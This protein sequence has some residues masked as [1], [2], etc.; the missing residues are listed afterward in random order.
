MALITNA[1]VEIIVFYLH[2][3]ARHYRVARELVA[4]SRRE[5][6]STRVYM[7]E[8]WLSTHTRVCDAAP[9]TGRNCAGTVTRK[10]VRMDP[11]CV[12]VADTT[13]FTL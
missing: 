1:V 6:D 4:N 2:T 10:R 5:K 7:H 8:P 9:C 11:L 13:P 3:R 12:S